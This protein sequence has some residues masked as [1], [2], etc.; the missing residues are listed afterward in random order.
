VRKCLVAGTVIVSAPDL[1]FSRRLNMQT[2][3]FKVPAMYGDHHVVEV[4]RLL[5]ELP[6]VED[7]YA[8]SSFQVVEVEFDETKLDPDRIEA[9]L[10][11]AGYLGELPV[12]AENETPL[13]RGNGQRQGYFRH[14][15]AHANTGQVSFAQKVPYAG[16]PLWP[17]PGIGPLKN[18]PQK[19]ASVEEEVNG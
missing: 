12:P 18:V 1:P 9:T 7:V 11:E 13:T 6:G 14:T 17:C 2:L 10:D 3:S 19:P 5:L 16:R 15:A 8:S 4:R